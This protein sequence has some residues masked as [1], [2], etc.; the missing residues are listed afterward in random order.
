MLHLLSIKLHKNLANGKM[1]TMG[2]DNCIILCKPA[3]ERQT[4]L[5]FNEGRDAAGTQA[6]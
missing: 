1:S 6:N 2:M 5:Y 3:S 4:I